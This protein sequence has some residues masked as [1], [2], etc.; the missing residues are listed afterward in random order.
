MIEMAVIRVELIDT[1]ICGIFLNSISVWSSSV[2]SS[3]SRNS[4]Q[5]KKK[6]EKK[7]LYVLL[8]AVIYNL[9]FF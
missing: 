9:D 2:S 7:S 5:K 4:M 8:I 6:K 1:W 3:F